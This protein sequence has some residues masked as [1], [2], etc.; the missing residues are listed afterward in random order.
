MPRWAC[1]I[2]L[3][4]VSVRVERLQ[5][6]S[7]ADAEREGIEDAA[8]LP[9]THFKDYSNNGETRSA[10]YSF[11]TLWESI[12]GPGRWDANPWVWV[13][14]FAPYTATARAQAREGEG[15]KS[16]SAEREE[17]QAVDRPASSAGHAQT[18]KE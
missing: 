10:Q 15:R 13:V 3:E 18:T 12:N 14:E 16:R 2:V 8:L 11:E 17:L 9:L 7:E 1:R 5:D 4:V 6:I